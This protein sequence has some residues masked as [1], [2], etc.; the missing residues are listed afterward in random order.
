MSQGCKNAEIIVLGGKN[1]Q[2]NCVPGCRGAFII[3][4]KG[5]KYA[6]AVL[7]GLKSVPLQR[8]Y[9]Y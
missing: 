3:V 2:I 6:S 7:G 1:A 9:N 4:S 5:T 8:V